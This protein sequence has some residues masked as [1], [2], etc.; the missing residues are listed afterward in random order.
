MAPKYPVHNKTDL[1]KTEKQWNALG[2]SVIPGEIGEECYTNKTHNAT[3]LYFLPA[4]VRE[5]PAA[6]KALHDAKLASAK[7][8]REKDRKRKEWKTAREWAELGRIVGAGEESRSAHSLNN[9]FGYNK[10][11]SEEKRF[12]GMGSETVNVYPIGGGGDYVTVRL[13]RPTELCTY[14]HISQTHEATIE[15][16]KA[17]IARIDKNISD[18]WDKQYAQIEKIRYGEQSQ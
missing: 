3:A 18:H 5:D 4:Q 11:T 2:Y 14:Y 8:K 15:E 9:E 16:C 10:R 13:F 1:S 7:K 12:L 17:E 6:A